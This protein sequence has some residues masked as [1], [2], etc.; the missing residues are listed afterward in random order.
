M[1][2]ERFPIT[3]LLG[4]QLVAMIA[5]P[6][7]VNRTEPVGTILGIC[8]AAIGVA[9]YFEMMM[10]PI[11][12]V[13]KPVQPITTRAANVVLGVGAVAVVGSTLAGTSY[14]VQ[15]GLAE[16][17]AINAIFTPF[18]IWLLFGLV[19]HLWLFRE[20]LATRRRTI[21]IAVGVAALQMWSGLERAILGQSAAFVVTVLVLAVLVR[22]IRLRVI[23]VVLLLIPLLWPPIY[24]LRETIRSNITGQMSAPRENA[25]LDRLQLDKQMAAVD[26]LVPAPKGLEPPSLLTLVRTG[27]LPSFIDSDRPPIDTGSRLSM[28]LGGSP[29]NSQSATMF[30]NVYIFGGWA[31]VV[32]MSA[33]L[34][35]AMGAMMRR[36]SSW[37]LCFAAVIYLYGV[38][39]NANYPNVVPQMLQASV[40][41]LLTY[42]LVRALSREPKSKRVAP[43]PMVLDHRL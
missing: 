15:L 20:G 38:S 35:L 12:P 1:W 40:S 34:A 28:A 13:D 3:M 9:L 17:L 21:I 10:L 29:T 43:R 7:V 22:L 2:V 41:M 36:R 11:L 18:T 8:A 24:D 33:V 27:L 25:A 4:A 16:V 6:A 23:V 39:F 42:A 19:L 14:A 31:G 30:G 37:A 26:R 5:I 32:V